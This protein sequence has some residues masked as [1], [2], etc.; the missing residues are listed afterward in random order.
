MDEAIEGF[1]QVALD[2][3]KDTAAREHL[4]AA[5]QESGE[6]LAAEGNFAK[7]AERYQELADLNPRDAD[8]RNSLGALYARAGNLKHAIEEFQAALA[9]DPAHQAARRNLDLARQKLR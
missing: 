4:A 3:P 1:R 8:L 9:I 6:T 7:A 2:D 5:L